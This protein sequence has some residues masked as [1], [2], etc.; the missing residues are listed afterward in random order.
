MAETIRGAAHSSPW[1]VET[2]KE[3]FDRLL[4]NMNTMIG[5]HD[6]R[7][8]ERFK[9]QEMA[10]KQAFEASNAAIAKA[11][12][13]QTAYN[14]RSNEFRAALDDQ[15]KQMLTRIEAESRFVNMRE[16][17]DQNREQIE[18]LRRG[19]TRIEGGTVA[20]ADR[21]KQNNWLI[22]IIVTVA[23]SVGINFIMIIV[24][25]IYFLAGKN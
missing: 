20:L 17:I 24:G 14:V 11:E 4:D 3:L 21:R 12:I 22:G 16:L 5:Q 13:A 10:V 2:A 15:S 23:L 1:T 6:R 8:E 25:F 9:A 19:E 18:L 7:Y